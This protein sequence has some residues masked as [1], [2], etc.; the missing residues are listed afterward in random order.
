MNDRLRQTLCDIVAAHGPSV[1]DDAKRFGDLLRASSEDRAGVDALLRALEAHVPARLTVLTESPTVG[2]VASGLVRRLVEEHGLSEDA[3]RWAVDAWAVALGKSPD[4]AAGPALNDSLAFHPT[5]AAPRRRNRLLWVALPLVA[6]LAVLGAWWWYE[7]RSEVGRIVARADGIH[8][9]S[10][11]ADGRRLLA[12]CYDRTLRL[13]DVE[14]GAER[15]RLEGH[16]GTPASVA[17]SPDGR[18]ALSCGGRVEQKDTKFFPVD[19]EVRLWD[20]ESGTE[21]RRFGEHS[22][23]LLGVAFSPDGRLALSCG[24]GYELKNGEYAKKDNKPI[25]AGCVVQVWDV[26]SGAEVRKFEGHKEQ[27]RCAAF[28]PD[29]R[30]VVSGANDATLRVWDLESGKEVKRIGTDN[31]VGVS[32]LAVSPDGRRLLTGDAT[33]RLRLWDLET[34]E[35]VFDPRSAHAESVRAVAFSPDGRRALSGG[36]D[37][38]VRLWDLDQ[39][40]EVRHF[41]GHTRSVTGVAFLGDDRR[42]VSSSADSTLR[43][44]RLPQ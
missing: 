43:I 35:E 1:A 20:L 23:P 39:W 33:T 28:T 36:D 13:W 15:R 27:V 3:A 42:A 22:V 41:K 6:V 2:P 26:A 14:A 17:L 4:G 21:L 5:L 32:C 12:G 16:Q 38:T 19:C 37:Y 7:Q 30:R 29:G 11:S 9:I 44:W 25:P 31:K 18:L 10:A 40:T 8:T 34:G 24:G